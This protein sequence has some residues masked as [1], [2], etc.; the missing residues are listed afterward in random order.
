MPAP[1]S[2]L[3]ALF[4]AAVT[5]PA[6]SPAGV[7][8]PTAP[9]VTD[10]ADP[11]ATGPAASDAI[12]SQSAPPDPAASPTTAPATSGP[13]PSQPAPS[14]SAAS[15]TTGPATSGAIASPPD[16][17]THRRLV[18][19]N[20]YA[21]NWSIAS[22]RPSGDFSLFLGS[23]LRPR[24]GL[25]G[26][27]WTTALG[28]E[29]TLS[30]GAADLHTVFFSFPGDYGLF[31]HRHHLAALGF[32]ARDNRLFYQF[33]GGLLLHATTLTALEAEVR[34]GCVLGVRRPTRIKGIV[35][36]Q[37]RLVGVL[38]GVPLPQFGVFAG[39]MLF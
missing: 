22:G 15:P 17:A 1:T 14:N 38:D 11:P 29:L 34:L 23:S 7:T 35:G 24:L 28:Y 36:A 39:W 8:D 18:L 2:L 9:A 3:V 10:P 6:D 30:V 5:A 12:P 32:G 4:A 26:R 37:V 21:I 33:G 16:P 25:R 31:Y 19:A 27:V 13:I 20:H